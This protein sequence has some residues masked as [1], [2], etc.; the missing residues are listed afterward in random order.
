MKVNYMAMVAAVSLLGSGAMVTSC[1]QP[2]TDA[3]AE[4][5]GADPCGAAADPCGAQ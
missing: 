4:A 2:S 1:A 3:P 5:D